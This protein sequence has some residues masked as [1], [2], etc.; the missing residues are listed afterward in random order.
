MAQKRKNAGQRVPGFVDDVKAL[1]D[2]NVHKV[3]MALP[4]TCLLIFTIL[5]LIY[6][7]CMAFT[8]FSKEGDHLVLFDWVGLRNFALLFDT[9]STVGSQFWSVLK[10][11]LV[12][13]FFATFLNFILG[14]I[15]AIIINRPTIKFKGRY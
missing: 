6:M 14:T 12:W 10:W 13:A 4:F 7:V 9:N 15:V 2:E 5:P 3:L 1:F 8:N 11:T